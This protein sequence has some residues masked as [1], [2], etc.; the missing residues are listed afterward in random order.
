MVTNE[1]ASEEIITEQTKNSL[2]RARLRGAARFYFNETM[3]TLNYLID[4]IRMIGELSNFQLIFHFEETLFNFYFLGF[5]NSTG[6]EV[7][8]YFNVKRPWHQKY[9]PNLITES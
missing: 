9:L 2:S 7:M 5:V 4:E 6:D 1:S 3:F 8:E